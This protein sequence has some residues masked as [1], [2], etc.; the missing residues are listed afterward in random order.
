MIGILVLLYQSVPIFP[1][2][3]N[4][5][6]LKIRLYYKRRYSAM[7]KFHLTTILIQIQALA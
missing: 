1:Q 4:D 6:P 5:N 2:K 7:D 3:H